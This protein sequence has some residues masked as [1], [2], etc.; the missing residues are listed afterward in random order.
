MA[1]A[2]IENKQEIELFDEDNGCIWQFLL[3]WHR[4]SIR[5]SRNEQFCTE[6]HNA[7][8]P[9]TQKYLEQLTESFK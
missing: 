1:L 9:P 5:L 2:C 8:F 6:F 7:A 4:R 3:N